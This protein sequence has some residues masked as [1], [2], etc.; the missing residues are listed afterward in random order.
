[1]KQSLSLSCDLPF[2]K[3]EMWRF[4]SENSIASFHLPVETASLTNDGT[5][6]VRIMMVKWHGQF[7]SLTER[8]TEYIPFKKISWKVENDARGIF[9]LYKN[10]EWTFE[11]DEKAR[12]LNLNVTYDR[13]DSILARLRDRFFENKLQ[14]VIEKIKQHAA[15]KVHQSEN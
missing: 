7:G 8:C 13:K 2:S 10:L 11:V 12:R 5:E 9:D 4:M 3:D 14:K 1:M 15:Q 6:A